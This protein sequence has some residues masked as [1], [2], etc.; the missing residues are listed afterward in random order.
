MSKY[1]Y[2]YFENVYTEVI[3]KGETFCPEMREK[4]QEELIKMA[5]QYNKWLEEQEENDTGTISEGTG[6]Q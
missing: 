6:N 5:E 4:I 1:D 2:E 3:Q